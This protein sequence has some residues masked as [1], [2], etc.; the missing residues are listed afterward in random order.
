MIGIIPPEKQ[1]ITPCAVKETWVGKYL[2]GT[3][4]KIFLDLFEFDIFTHYIVCF[5]TN[6]QTCNKYYHKIL[7]IFTFSD[8]TQLDLTKAKN[9]IKENLRRQ[10]T[11]ILPQAQKKI[12][13]YNDRDRGPIR[14]NYSKTF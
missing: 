7:L 9:R 11:S 10:F 1:R 2:S 14:V 3:S 12:S 4:I 6:L 8:P 13:R 5:N